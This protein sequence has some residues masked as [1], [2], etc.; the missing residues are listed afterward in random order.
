MPNHVHV[1]VRPIAGIHLQK[2]LQTWK[3]RVAR[4]AN[5]HLGR[6][7]KA[8]WQPE[9]FDRIIRD[10]EE[11]S[12]IARYIRKKPVTAGL[13]Q[14]EEDWQWGSAWAGWANSKRAD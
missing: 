10:P 12:R 8:F 5:L 11:K 6:E 13:R 7:G 2:I 14:S 1:I 4:A 3:G 9:S